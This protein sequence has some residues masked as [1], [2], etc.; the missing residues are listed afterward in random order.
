MTET[1]DSLL[2]HALRARSNAEAI[3]APGRPPLTYAELGRQLERDHDFLRRSGFGCRSRIG[4][5]MPSGAEGLAVTAAVARSAACAHVDPDLEIDSLTRLISTMRLDGVIVPEGSASNAA[6][7]ARELGIALIEL[8][9]GPVQPAGSHELRTESGRTPAR[10]ELPG[11][12][13]LAFIWHT[14]G[15]T[16]VPKI[17]PF[18]Q[19]RM[20]FDVRKRIARRRICGSDRGLLASTLTSAATPRSLLSNLAAGAAT[21]HAAGLPPEDVIG[22][23]ESLGPTYYYA[24]PALHSRLAELIERRGGRLKHRLRVIYSSFADLSP[25]VRCRLEKALAVPMVVVYG[26][27]ELGAIAETPL[28]PDVA[29]P[30]SV[31][32]PV[33][34]LAIADADG[35]FLAAGQDGEVWVRG[36]EVIGAYES[37]AQANGESFRD[38]WFRTGDCGLVDGH[39]FLHLTGRL[40]DAI[41]RG[42]VKVAPS[43]IELALESHPA[44][45]EAAAFARRHATLGEDVCAAVVFEDGRI[46]SEAELRRFV[47]HRL[48]AA[49]V[50]TRI[51]A[52]AAMPRNAAGKLKRTELAAFGEALLRQAWQRPQGPHE[53]RMAEIFSRVLRLDDIG[54]GDQFFDRGGDSLRAVELLERIQESFGVSLTMDDLLESPSVAAL[55]KLISQSAGL[56]S[57][58]PA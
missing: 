40:K 11:P 21:I 2:A 51:V 36:P 19:G 55:A 15:T 1:V 41:N 46:A 37:P 28:P 34:E 29:P 13:D 31:G 6:R 50:P 5:A 20:C 9:T 54:R 52:A 38:G 45:R 4:V 24:A 7:A 58:Q 8:S 53:E 30:G 43:E 18:E 35:G 42:G 22:A 44:V 17:V 10:P 16:G 57:G 25:D 56:A 47:R 32:R 27:T 26:M 48:S 39:G 3:V 14:S 23:I 12:D 49:K 33:V